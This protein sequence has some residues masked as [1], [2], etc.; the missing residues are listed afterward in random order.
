[1]HGT[2]RAEGWKTGGDKMEWGGKPFL[3][4]PQQLSSLCTF[5]SL[6]CCFQ[7][8]SEDIEIRDITIIIISDTYWGFFF[9][10]LNLKFHIYCFKVELFLKGLFLFYVSIMIFSYE[11]AELKVSILYCNHRKAES[12]SACIT[13]CITWNMASL[14]SYRW[15]K[16]VNNMIL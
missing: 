3:S 13:A 11:L 12:H 1:M 10:N 2:G 15:G 4:Y 5:F 14:C 8:T 7:L 16:R 9:S 6:F